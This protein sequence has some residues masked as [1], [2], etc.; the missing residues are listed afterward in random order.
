VKILAL[1]FRYLGDAVLMTPAL[2]ALADHFPSS[3]LHVVVAAEVAPLLEH[4][5][6]LRRVWAVPRARGKANILKTWPLIRALR[7]QRF[8][9]SVAFSGNDRGAITSLLCGARQRL[10]V[11]RTGGFLGQRLCYTE[12][13]AWERGGHESG[14]NLQLISKWGIA[15]PAVPRL[16]LRADPARAAEAER[17]LPE[18]A[19]LCH[20]AT[21]QAKK[22]WPLGHWAELYRQSSALGLPLVFSTGITAREQRLLEEFRTLAPKARTLPVLPDLRT[23]LAVLAR[24]RLVVCGCTGPLHFAAGLGVPTIALFGPT[25]AAMWAPPGEGHRAIQAPACTCS[26]D[27]G[28][29]LSPTPCMEKISPEAVFPLVLQAWGCI[30]HLRVG[31]GFY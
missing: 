24:A 30:S 22:D 21:S 31:G 1:Q 4:S 3:E 9:R 16:E 27:T 10:G 12:T 18:P 29:C 13:I 25:S 5:P 26:G 19:I 14:P 28:V 11:R 6:W 17:L 8:D 2:R 20:L 23:F 15:A 7:G